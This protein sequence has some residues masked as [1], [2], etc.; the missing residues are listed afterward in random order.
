MQAAVPSVA[1]AHGLLERDDLFA[2]LGQA[3]GDA[4]AGRGRL[5]FVAGEAGAGKTVLVRHF[6][7]AQKRSARILWGACEALFTPRPLGPILDI[8]Q[9]TGGE[10]ARL[11]Q[12][13][14]IPYHV[15]A[16]LTRQLHEQGP[17][18]LVL[19]DAHWADEATLDVLRLVARRIETIPALVVTTYRADSLGPTHLLRTVL[20]E[21]AT[22]RAIQ[23]IRLPPLSLEAVATLA[24]PHDVDSYELHRITGGNPFFVTEVLATGDEE[25]PET[26]RDAVL[27]RASRVSPEAR[28]VLEA[29]AIVPPSVGLWLLEAL[30]NEAGERLDECLSSGMLTEAAGNISYSHELARLAVEGS[31]PAGRKV[32]LHKKILAALK[33]PPRGAV[34]LTQ[35]AHHAAAAGD[36]EAVLEFAPRAAARASSVGAHREAA[37]LYRQALEFSA[38]L[39]PQ[40]LADLLERR[41]HEC[42]LT[43]QADEATEALKG[44]VDCYRQLGDRLSE[45]DKLRQLSSI[46][47]CPG[48]AKEAKLTGVQAVE[49]L[50]QL[51]PGPELAHAYANLSFLCRRAAELEE[52]RDWGSRALELAERNDDA[53]ALIGAHLTLGMLKAI[54]DL[55]AGR[56]QLERAREHAEQEG[57]EE[58][59]ADALL[60]LAESST[61]HRSYGPAETYLEQALEY[62]GERGFDLAELYLVSFRARMKL[63]QGHWQEAAEAAALVLRARAVSTFPR[64]WGLVVLALVRARRGDPGVEPLLDSALQLAYPTGELP[65]IA[66]VA[67]ARAEVAWLRNDSQGVEQATSGALELALAREAAWEIG[68]LACW[69]RRSGV[70]EHI[71]GAAEPYALELAGEHARASELW[72]QLGCRYEAALALSLSDDERS[73]RRAHAALIELG[74]RPAATIVARRLRERGARGVPSGPRRATRENPAQLTARE[75]EVLRLVADGLRNSEI[76]HRLFLSTRTVDHHVA[77]VLRKLNARTRSEAVARAKRRRILEDQ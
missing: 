4:A 75:L 70:E 10:L 46:L 13:D 42:Y 31:I 65:R 73:L 59:V 7:D 19:E 12:G 14:A 53:K 9:V 51:T 43:D 6:C 24:E 76:A 47:W 2:E 68:E 15:A 62:C 27:A 57:L 50:E 71:A 11:V 67:A 41:S 35:L 45:G 17:T 18:V 44:A 23:R 29:V 16:Q 32:G 36:G 72:M 8:A 63:N 34:D 74:S 37:A 20:G 69:R 33:S 3:F 39:Q 66:P 49:V 38:A 58:D 22:G 64:T 52:A 55:K 26:V 61:Q 1:G 25:I 28:A 77:A 30:G 5:V 21:L 60:G 56:H 48:R 40:A 54:S